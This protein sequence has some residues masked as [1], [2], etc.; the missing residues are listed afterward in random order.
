MSPRPWRIVI[1]RLV[2]GERHVVKRMAFRHEARAREVFADLLYALP[3]DE[4]VE[5][6]EPMFGDPL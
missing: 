2:D 4:F 5:F 3:D 1:R 6:Q